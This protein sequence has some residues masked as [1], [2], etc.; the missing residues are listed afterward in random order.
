MPFFPTL[1]PVETNPEQ[2][3]TPFSFLR[4]K[5]NVFSFNKVG[6]YHVGKTFIAP[7]SNPPFSFSKYVITTCRNKSGLDKISCEIN[8]LNKLA[9]QTT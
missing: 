7:A 9:S 5:H 8:D 2:H 3:A 6:K 1:K 4:Y